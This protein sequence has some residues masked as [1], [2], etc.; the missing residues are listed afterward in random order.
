MPRILNMQREAF[1]ALDRIDPLAPSRDKFL[2]P[3]GVI[4]LD[5][6]SLGALPRST[7]ARV[8]SVIEKEWGEDLVTSWNRHDWIGMP[9]RVG[10]KIAR[11]IG[12]AA[13]EVVVAESTSINLFKVL[14]VAL[15]MRPERRVIVSETENFPT[16]LY[17]AEGLVQL[18]DRDYTLRLVAADDLRQALGAETA[19][20]M[21]T[22]VNFRTGAIH[23]LAALT[24]AAHAAGA[25]AIWDLSHS[26][27]AVPVDLNEARA[28]FA[29]GCGYKY[30]NG[31]PGAPAFV[32]AAAR[33]QGQAP[34][35]LCGWLGH[36]APFEFAASYRAA[37]GI[38]Q[39]LVGTP[40]ILAL[41]ALEEGVDLLL[42]ANLTQLRAK[43]QALTEAFIALVEAR[44]AGLGLSLM[45]P[46]DPARR[47]SQV[48][49]AHDQGYAVMQA[50][51]AR[52]V[53]GD[54]RAPD[55]LRF[56]FSPLYTRHVDVWDAAETLR[57]VLATGA[58]R[59]PE[60]QKRAA[61]P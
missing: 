3:P 1:E 35:P 60:F 45:T 20:L 12:A 58:W 40:P 36:A 10:D 25:L 37:E 41:A 24:A 47:G 11:L 29:I 39:Y 54:F 56:G 8:S 38:R 28:D 61:V 59:R 6:N 49:F 18:L 53:V 51:I 2:L 34:Q 7:A 33:H 9:E 44:C 50:L 31:G 46:R 57:D 5:G 15:K 48:S 22:Q 27:G 21:L 16:D 30:L 43:S 26:A 52:G 19:V 14:A 32:Y 17:M 42:Q 13:G 55:L 4:Y 23:D